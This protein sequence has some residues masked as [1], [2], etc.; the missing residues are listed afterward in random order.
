MRTDQYQKLQD[1]SEKLTDVV[2]DELDP[3]SWPGAGTQL[4]ELTREARG[5]RY[6]CK[7]NAAATLSLLT[8]MQSLL[9]VIERSASGDAP[10]EDEHEDLDAEISAAEKEAA[11]ILSK[12]Q[13]RAY[14]RGK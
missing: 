3:E 4:H 9:G 5:D 10:P 11:K 1:L 7:K 8:K 13:G 12:I 2:V 6:W 14:D